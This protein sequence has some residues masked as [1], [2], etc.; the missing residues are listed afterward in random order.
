MGSLSQRSAYGESTLP[1]YWHENRESNICT[2]KRL[3]TKISIHGSLGYILLSTVLRQE[4]QKKKNWRFTYWNKYRQEREKRQSR[5]GKWV[6]WVFI[7]TLGIYVMSWREACLPSLV[8]TEKW[9]CETHSVALLPHTH[10]HHHWLG[11][12]PGQ[13]CWRKK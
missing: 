4:V 13:Q 1:Y 8:Y 7:G 11:G 2:N 12:N 5:L 3:Q 10:S 9:P 6:N